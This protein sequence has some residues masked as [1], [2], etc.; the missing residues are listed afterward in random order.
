MRMPQGM[1]LTNWKRRVIG[2]FSVHTGLSA[3][4]RVEWMYSLMA[5]HYAPLRHGHLRGLM[6]SKQN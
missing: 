2:N 5:F 1:V 6:Q 3:S 4:N